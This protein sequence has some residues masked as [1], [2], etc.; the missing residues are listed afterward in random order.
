MSEENKNEVVDQR[1]LKLDDLRAQG[2]NPFANGFTASAT[3]NDVALAHADRLLHLAKLVHHRVAPVHQLGHR[4]LLLLLDD[5]ALSEHGLIF[6][7]ECLHRDTQSVEH[8]SIKTY[9]P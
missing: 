5:F 8:E 1:R 4:A 3:A 9:E 6:E 2:I 7:F